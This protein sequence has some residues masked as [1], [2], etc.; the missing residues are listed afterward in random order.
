MLQLFVFNALFA[1]E[2]Q[3]LCILGRY[4]AIEN[5]LLLLLLLLLLLTHLRLQHK[6]KPVICLN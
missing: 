3:R 4:G 1:S 2:R 6:Y 5:V